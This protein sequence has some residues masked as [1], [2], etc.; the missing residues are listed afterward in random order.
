MSWPW[1]ISSASL[2]TAQ[3]GVPMNASRSVISG[4]GLEF[5]GLGQLLDRHGALEPRQMVDE[6]DAVQVIHL[7]LQAGGQQAIGLQQLLVAVAVEIFAFDAG[8][9]FDIVPDFG[10]RQAA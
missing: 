5:L 6:Q 8:G 4:A 2:G 10:N 3:S 9:A 7:M 1:A